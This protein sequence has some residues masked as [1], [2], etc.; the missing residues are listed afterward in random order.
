[1]DENP[2]AA[3]AAPEGRADTE[4]T[5]IA[6]QPSMPDY[7]ANVVK[8]HFTPFE[9]NLAF[10]RVLIPF[11]A[12]DEVSVSLFDHITPV[13]RIGLPLVVLPSL[14]K[15]L[16]LQLRKAREQGLLVSGEQNAPK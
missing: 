5:L 16:E 4:A 10:G 3:T 9:I 6:V 8:A 2:K 14:I 7:Y 1:M 13:A 15:L 12:P 11:D